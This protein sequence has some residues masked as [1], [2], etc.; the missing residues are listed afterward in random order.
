MNVMTLD[1][2][3]NAYRKDLADSRLEGRVEAAR[4]VE[5]RAARVVRGHLDLR[6]EPAADAALDTQLLFGEPVTLFE[7][8]QDGWAWVQSGADGYVGYVEA[9]GLAEGEV[10]PTHQVAALRTFRFSAPDIK[11]QPLDHL[12]LGARF[13]ATDEHD[14]FLELADSGFVYA[15]HAEPVGAIHPDYV[16]TAERFLDVPYLWGGRT[17]LGLDCSALVQTVFRLAGRVCPR[18]TYMQRDDEGLGP[19]VEEGERLQRGDLIFSPGHVAIASGA[20]TLVHANA[21]H[22]AVAHEDL[23]GFR[24]RLANLDQVIQRVRRPSPAGE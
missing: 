15:P 22:L 14:R 5:G 24:H 7:G 21:Y 3:L 16:A 8:R 10:E 18:D 13:S 19:E 1:P 6:R 2:R 12:S 23:A 20:E 9:A 17:A 4:F 11:S